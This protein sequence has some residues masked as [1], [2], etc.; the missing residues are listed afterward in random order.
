MT[1]VG[2]PQGAVVAGRDLLPLS[3]GLSS[4]QSGKTGWLLALTCFV[5]QIVKILFGRDVH[6]RAKGAFFSWLKGE[7]ALIFNCVSL[8]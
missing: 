8:Q 1:T 6:R 2:V 5:V 4:S 3:T 7:L